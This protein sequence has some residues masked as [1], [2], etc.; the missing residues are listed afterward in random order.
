MNVATAKWWNHSADQ[1]I[2]K[3]PAILRALGNHDPPERLTVLGAT[4]RRGDILKHDSWAATAIYCNDEGKRIICKFNRTQPVFWVPLAWIGRALAARE[5]RFLS[6]LSNVEL[7]PKNLGNVTSEGQLLRNAIARSYVPGVTLRVKEEINP[8]VFHELRGLLQ[9]IHAQ[10]M[11]YVD[12]HKLENIIVDPEKH[13]YL[14]DFQVCFGLSDKWPGNGRLA[15]FLLDK[16]QEIDV[17]C[18]NKHATRLLPHTLTREQFRLYSKVPRL[19]RVHRRFA[20]PLRALRRKLLVRLRIR[21]V[22]GAA[23]SELEP[24]DAYHP[25]PHRHEQ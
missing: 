15:R 5:S 11:A 17:Y 4:F 12:L 2:R 19:V 6:K 18:L 3:R 8:P 23:S 21:A 7:V 25:A 24:E 1:K 14:I 20:A 22:G 10:D 13:P 16:L 9:A